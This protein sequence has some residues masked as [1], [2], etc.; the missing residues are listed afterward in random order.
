MLLCKQCRRHQQGN[1]LPALDR[2]ERGP[3]GHLGLAE[4]DI[5]EYQ[6]IHRCGSFHVGFHICDRRQLIPRFLVGESG[7]ELSLPGRVTLEGVTGG[8]GAATMQ[9]HNGFSN[10]GNLFA[11][12]GACLRPVGTAH[13]RQPRR[14]SAGVVLLHDR[15]TGHVDHQELVGVL[16]GHQERGVSP[17]V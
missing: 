15:G 9:L 14:L 6:P 16:R 8:C 10:S 1:L 5:S 7:L 2:L 13:A 4:S 12:L 3:Q 17:P 11:D